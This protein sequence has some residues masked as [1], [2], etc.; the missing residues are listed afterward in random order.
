MTQVLLKVTTEF[1][2][3]EDRVRMAGITGDGQ[4]V[5]I[6]LTR[7]LVSVLLPVL[8]DWLEGRSAPVSDEHRQIM[9]E[10]EQQAA[11]NSIEQSEPVQ[12]AQDSEAM[13]A[14]AVDIS[15]DDHNAYLTF[16]GETGGA[17]RLPMANQVLRQW[18][19]ILYRADCAAEWRLPQ[20]PAWITGAAALQSGVALH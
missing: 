17:F 10:F 16:R 13:L 14:T 4:P 5:V 18:L 15:H 9:Q 1:S 11:F 19:Q 2:P 12:A 8:L 20:W 7:R 6:W 3:L